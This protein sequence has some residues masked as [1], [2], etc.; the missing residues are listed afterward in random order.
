M[1]NTEGEDSHLTT[2]QGTIT[3]ELTIYEMV[4][5]YHTP[6]DVT[7]VS[8]NGGERKFRFITVF[9]LF[10]YV[11][12]LTFITLLQIDAHEAIYFETF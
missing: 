8:C 2:T 7:S 9:F 5:A 4:L 12:C 6:V 10:N 3:L 1:G 11:L